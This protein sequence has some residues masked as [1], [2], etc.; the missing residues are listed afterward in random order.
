M[1]LWIFGS[2]VICLF[3]R[4]TLLLTTLSQISSS[5]LFLECD[6]DLNV[7]QELIIFACFS[8][9]MITLK[10]G[11]RK[12]LKRDIR[13]SSLWLFASIIIIWQLS[14]CLLFRGLQH[15]GRRGWKYFIRHSDAARVLSGYAFSLRLI[16][17]VSI[18]IMNFLMCLYSGSVGSDSDSIHD[19]RALRYFL[20][21]LHGV[22]SIPFSSHC[23]DSS[24]SLLLSPY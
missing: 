18:H 5:K 20:A 2:N 15:A 24:F 17:Q 8:P 3:C 12:L 23:A 1:L 10:D 13:R 22:R 11:T 6:R 9:P 21:I 7:R 16:L 14:F 19:E 4:I